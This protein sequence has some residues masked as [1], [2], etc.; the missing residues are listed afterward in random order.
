M[1]GQGKLATDEQRKVN[2][3]DNLSVTKGSHQMKFGVDYRWLSP[4]S[5]PFQYRQFAEFSGV[6]CPAPPSSCSGYV[7]SGEAALAETSAYQSDALLSRN[8]SFYGQ[9]TWKITPEYRPWQL[10]L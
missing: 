4:F 5:S 9:D 3:I 7:F 6:T 8:F 1:Y 10:G 2:F